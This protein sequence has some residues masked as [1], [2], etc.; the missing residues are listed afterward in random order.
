MLFHR[1]SP[2][3]RTILLLTA[4]HRETRPPGDMLFGT[5]GL[6]ITE[7]FENLRAPEA[8]GRAQPATRSRFRLERRGLVLAPAR[9]RAPSLRRAHNPA[10][11]AAA[12]REVRRGWAAWAGMGPSAGAR[13]SG[14]PDGSRVWGPGVGGR[15]PGSGYGTRPG[16]GVMGRGSWGVGLGPGEGAPGSGYGLGPGMDPV[17]EDPRCGAPA[18][19]GGGGSGY[20]TRAWKEES[21]K[22]EPE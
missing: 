6:L 2:V 7:S 9:R 17:K 11:T 22:E 14:R 1:Q 13:V 16:K 18:W 19:A 10:S 3:E 4:E 20:G 12:A 5:R 15:K 8:T 21:G